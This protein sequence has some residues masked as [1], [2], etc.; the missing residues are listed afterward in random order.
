LFHQPTDN[1]KAV[2]SVAI[3]TETVN[4]T[5]T[6]TYALLTGV[7][8]VTVNQSAKFIHLSIVG[9]DGEYAIAATPATLG[10]PIA[11][12]ATIQFDVT[13]YASLSDWLAVFKLK[14]T[15]GGVFVISI[16]N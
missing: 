12:G 5:G 10:H 16:W 7:S 8:G 6:G 9:A 11:S 3:L 15:G 14:S 1:I 13:G 2:Q 4:Y